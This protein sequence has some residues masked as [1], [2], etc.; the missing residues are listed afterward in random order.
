MS[1]KNGFL[2]STIV[3]N[4]F[5]FAAVRS[6]HSLTDFHRRLH[7]KEPHHRV[8]IWDFEKPIGS[9]AGQPVYPQHEER[10]VH[11]DRSGVLW[12]PRQGIH[13]A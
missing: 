10:G 13:F 8:A 5:L 1:I 3:L 7:A 11:R 12:R 2:L 6:E 4:I 9:L